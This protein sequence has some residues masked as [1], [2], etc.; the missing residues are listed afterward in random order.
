MKKQL[1][2]SALSLV[3]GLAFGQ[4]NVVVQ[5]LS[6]ASIANGYANTYVTTAN[7]WA[8]PDMTIPANA[9]Q[10]EFVL[11]VD[12]SAADSLGCEAIVNGAEVDGKIAVIYRGTCNFSLKALNAQE[13][14]AIGVLLI[15]N[16]DEVIGM[17]GGDYGSQVT[18]P[19]AMISQSNGALIRAVLN[20]ETVI[21]FIGNNYG[22]F[23]NNLS[24]DVYDVLV[25]SAAAVPSLV[26]AN[27][28]EYQVSLGGFIHNFGSAESS[29]A[30]L[31]AIVTHDGNEVYNEVA[32]AGPLAS[33][34]SILITLPQFT[35]PTYSGEYIITYTA[36]SD[37]EDEF[38]NDNSHSVPLLFSDLVSYAP[39]DAATNLP[40]NTLSV[41][42]SEFGGL[43]RTCISFAD[44][45]ASRLAVTGMDFSAR[46]PVDLAEPIDSVL[47]NALVGTYA[48]L[49]TDPI[50][51]AYTLPTDAGLT[52]LANGN[53]TYASDL[54]NEVVYIPFDTPITLENNQ[55]YLFCAETLEPIIRHGWNEDVDYDQNA[56]VGGEPTSL[57]RNGSTWNNGFLNLSGAPTL[58]LKTIAANSIGIN[59]L[60]RV[61]LTAYPN[62]AQDLLRI[63]MKGFNGA[64]MLRIF[65]TTGAVVA[66]QKVAVGGNETM[67]VDM[68]NLANGTY[69]FHVDFEN[70]KRSD[71]RVVLAK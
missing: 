52:T 3:A 12:G 16:S 5:V 39:V 69:L 18:I 56:Q 46:T 66:E 36:E 50:A 24:M 70:G 71:F 13:A 30:R 9:V 43:F 17:L 6:P 68:S 59:E 55:R 22:A 11:A 1:F 48:Y 10:G 34:D 38:A 63:P 25:P 45:N 33:G 67:V 65:N 58:T 28:G 4:G 40:V 20:N 61:E 62:P 54:Q 8:T 57:I 47:T 31:R 53:Y 23:A 37:T 27:A 35:Q 42:P 44:T 64:A 49:W 26:A 29:D 21:G 2:T 51:N 41:V 60:D 19:V 32:S 14:G 7:G 15:S